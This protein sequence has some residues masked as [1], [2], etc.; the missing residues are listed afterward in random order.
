MQVQYSYNRYKYVHIHIRDKWTRVVC[1]SGSGIQK[2]DTSDLSIATI[3]FVKEHRVLRTGS[4]LEKMPDR[5]GCTDTPKHFYFST[6]TLS[7]QVQK[8]LQEKLFN[9]CTL[10]LKMLLAFLVV[11][12]KNKQGQL[13]NTM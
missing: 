10:L 9:V 11:R 2:I 12:K 5:V 1:A 6:T 3:V 13:S 4:A 8:Y 7:T